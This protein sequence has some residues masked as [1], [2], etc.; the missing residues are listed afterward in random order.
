MK[1][2]IDARFLNESGVGRYLRNLIKGLE[3]ID[4]E[5][6]YFIFLLGRDLEDFKVGKNFQK[7]EADY[8]WYGFAE[9]FKFP[10][11]IKKFG[12]DLM[13]FPH[14]NVPVFYTGK[15][16]VT[17]HDL[18]HQHHSMNRATTL[19]PFTFKI[20]QIGYKK[21]FKKATLNSEK[22]L[23]PSESVRKLLIDEWH[24]DSRKIIVTQEA[25]D[26]KLI[27]INN[28]ISKQKSQEILKKFKINTPYIFYVGNAH[29]HKNVE[30]LIKAYLEIKKTKQDIKL[31][32]SGNNHF[33]WDRIKRENPDQGII[34]TGFIKDEELVALYKQAEVFVLPSLEEGFG[35]PILE[36][37][38]CGCPV[39]ASDVSSI[40]EVG[41]DAAL[42][43]NPENVFDMVEKISRVL[44]NLQ[45]KKRMISKGSKR[46]KLFSWKKMAEQ[47]LSIYQQSKESLK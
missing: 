39:V 37:M 34:Y 13:H 45:L 15:F 20:K 27:S 1:V 2:G 30:G 4:K 10:N 33:F 12:P 14:F 9:Q 43:F 25:V 44:S 6:E 7:V 21:V 23:V 42:Y 24:V 32:L 22:I 26:E 8:N 29:P 28:T 41:G 46:V 11:L 38:A 16:V 40:P 5:N 19:D 47:T 17:I 3:I 18:I 31:V 35:I 36:S